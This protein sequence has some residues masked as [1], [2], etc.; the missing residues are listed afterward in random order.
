M[1][2]QADGWH[3]V[4]TRADIADVT[5][6]Y[7]DKFA[8]LFG[9]TTEFGNGG[10]THMGPKPLGD[11]PAP[12]HSR[13]F[14]YTT[15]GSYLDVWQWKAS[16]GGMLGH[17]DDQYFG[18]PIEPKPAEVAGTARYQGGYWNDPGS[19]FYVYNFKGEPPGGY[20]GRSRSS[21]CPRISPAPW[22]PWAASTSAPKP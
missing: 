18:P 5:D 7:E 17:V 9:R 10:S 4:G 19:A 20:R 22:P 1:Q 16:R 11:K 6:F 13:G 8:I 2:K 12:L 15:D 14:H 21:G 3:L